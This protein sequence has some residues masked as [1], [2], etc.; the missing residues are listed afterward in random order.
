MFHWTDIKSEIDWQL[1]MFWPRVQDGLDKYGLLEPLENVGQRVA[2]NAQALQ[3]AF[4]P[5]VE[6]IR[7][8]DTPDIIK[9]LR[10]E[11]RAAEMAKAEA[12]VLIAP[13]LD[14]KP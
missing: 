14:Y 9:R 7:E 5:A 4:K 6:Y 1:S 10:A 11:R 12:A 8:E 13:A 2:D 3:D